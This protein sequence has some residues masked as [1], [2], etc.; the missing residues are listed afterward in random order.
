M[1][2]II[3]FLILFLIS[4]CK[5][6]QKSIKS[7]NDAKLIEHIIAQFSDKAKIKIDISLFALYFQE[8]PDIK[9]VYNDRT[10]MY[11]YNGIIITIYRFENQNQTKEF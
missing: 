11:T 3:Q 6:Q 10:D 4:S 8:K 9:E 7:I 2:S 1:K 5:A